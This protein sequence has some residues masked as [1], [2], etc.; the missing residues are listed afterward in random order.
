MS[1]NENHLEHRI[2]VYFDNLFSGV[3]S[4]QQLFE[5]KEELTT[6]MK[7]KSLITGPEV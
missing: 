5:L 2:T 4:S 3:G 1:K 7:E 6:N